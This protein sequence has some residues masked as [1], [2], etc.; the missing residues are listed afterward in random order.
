MIRATSEL[1]RYQTR[2][3]DGQ[4]QGLADTTAGK[5]GQHSGFRPHDL[6]EAALAACVNMSVRMYADHHGIPLSGATTTVSLDRANPDEVAFRYEVALE[7]DLTPEQRDRLL[8]AASACPVR[9]TLSKKIRF[10]LGPGGS[11]A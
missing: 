6:L 1:P 4:H 3:S 10:E 9:R 5:G 7:G 11:N 8:R 2:F